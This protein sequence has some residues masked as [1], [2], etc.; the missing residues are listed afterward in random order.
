MWIHLDSHPS[1]VSPLV[2]FISVNGKCKQ[3]DKEISTFEL[4]MVVMKVI[5]S[6]HTFKAIQTPKIYI[7][8][9]EEKLTTL[10]DLILPDQTLCDSFQKHWV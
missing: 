5:Y 7:R 9:R 10:P 1:D 4:Q 6:L 3:Y 8:F 2:T